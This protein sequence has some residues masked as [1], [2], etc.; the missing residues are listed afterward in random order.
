M[1]KYYKLA[2]PDGFDFHT[3]RTVNYRANI[4]ATVTAP[5]YEHTA[6]CGHGLH[7]SANPN[8]CFV[9]AK[10]PC[11]AYEVTPRLQAQLDTIAQWKKG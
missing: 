6:E 3:G 10:I 8:D 11:S 1:P 5:D 2:R 7:Y 4:G 9:G